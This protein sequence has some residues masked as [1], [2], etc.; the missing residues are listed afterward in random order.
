M[1]DCD[2]IIYEMN[3]LITCIQ[4]FRNLIFIVDEHG[5]VWKWGKM[6]ENEYA[7]DDPIK[8]DKLSN[9][10]SITCSSNGI[11]FVFKNGS[12]SYTSDF[13]SFNL[14]PCKIDDNVLFVFS[15]KG[16]TFSLCTGGKIYYH[17]PAIGQKLFDASSNEIKEICSQSDVISICSYDNATILFLR[18]DGILYIY[19]DN[20]LTFLHNKVEKISNSLI[21]NFDVKLFYIFLPFSWQDIWKVSGFKSRELDTELASLSGIEDMIALGE[22]HYALLDLNNDIRI[23][24]LD[25]NTPIL[26]QIRHFTQLPVPG[27]RSKSARK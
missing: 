10:N 12:L 22:G 9:V 7:A 16:N 2:L 15:D 3:N 6:D 19:K 24:R 17:A 1:D 21:V 20:V 4:T 26:K 23:V 25:V 5:F 11:Y 27:S 14:Q 8:I 13:L 18:A